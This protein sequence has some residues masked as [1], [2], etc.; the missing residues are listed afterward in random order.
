[1]LD[2]EDVFLVLAELGDVLFCILAVAAG[3]VA[4]DFRFRAGHRIIAVG[5]QMIVFGLAAALVAHAKAQ[6]E[7]FGGIGSIASVGSVVGPPVLGHLGSVGGAVAV[8]VGH[9]RIGPVSQFLGEGEPV[10]VGIGR[11]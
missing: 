6:G 2:A 11:K 10:A 3:M 4:V 5:H 9:G 8:A 7:H 1:P